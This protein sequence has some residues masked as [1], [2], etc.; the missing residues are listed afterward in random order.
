LPVIVEAPDQCGYGAFPE[1]IDRDWLGRW[2]HL[3]DADVS[4]A[5]RG[6]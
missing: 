2:C 1:D 6:T 5:R 4:L 3:S